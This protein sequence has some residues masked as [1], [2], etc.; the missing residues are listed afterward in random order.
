MWTLV[1]FSSHAGAWTA[2]R[3]PL[4][5]L[6]SKKVRVLRR[7]KEVK[8]GL[9]DGRE[10]DEAETVMEGGILDGVCGARRGGEGDTLYWT[11]NK[12]SDK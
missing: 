9:V 11:T 4:C 3:R 10:K 1:Y 8:D 2:A 5:P 12:E 7:T 6:L